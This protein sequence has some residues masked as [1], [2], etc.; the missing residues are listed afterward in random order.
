MQAV[1]DE[2]KPGVEG[3]ITGIPTRSSLLSRLKNW[4]DN[5]SWKVFFDT[6][7]RL[8]YNTAIRAGLND[9]EAQ[10]VVQETVV[11]VLKAMPNFQYDPKKGTFKGWLLR[12]T[13][14]R[15]IDHRRK[16]HYGP[17]KF[18]NESVALE[19]GEADILDRIPDPSGG[20]LE[21]I[22]EAEWEANLWKAAMD[23]LKAK[24]DLKQYQ[25]F[26]LYV[27][28]EWNVSEVARVTG[29]SCGQV[30]LIK[31]RVQKLLKEEFDRLCAKPF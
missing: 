2:I 24:V 22:W 9:A 27:V 25:I 14:R 10:D 18:Q 12:L 26:D 28:K 23:R 15:I 17:F 31:H 7:W 21:A 30:Y 3:C 1:A 29:V 8:I 16:Q 4:N 13:Q 19:D 5:E 20:D 11:S 6:Y